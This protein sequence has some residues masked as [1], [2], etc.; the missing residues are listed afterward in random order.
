[1][2][3][4]LGR[5]TPVVFVDEEKGKQHPF[6][7][8]TETAANMIAKGKMSGRWVQPAADDVPKAEAAVNEDILIPHVM[9]KSVANAALKELQFEEMAHVWCSN[10]NRD[11][12]LRPQMRY[13]GAALLAGAILIDGGNK[14]IML[15]TVKEAYSRDFIEDAHAERRSS[16]QA[17]SFPTKAGKYGLL[18][19]QVFSM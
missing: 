11:W 19:I 9:Q 4:K 12:L 16:I 15:K 2:L 10:L 8:N 3:V 1:M 17:S 14:S 6:L 13:C 18:N 5:W 7:T